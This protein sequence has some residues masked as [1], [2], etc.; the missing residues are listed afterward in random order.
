MSE[1]HDG[2]TP[3]SYIPQGIWRVVYQRL[4]VPELFHKFDMDLRTTSRQLKDIEAIGFKIYSMK[5]LSAKRIPMLFRKINFW[6]KRQI[7]DA[8]RL[9]D[10]EGGQW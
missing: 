4:D 5:R 2:L 3:E 1:F 6:L 10:F 9:A 8:K 7:R